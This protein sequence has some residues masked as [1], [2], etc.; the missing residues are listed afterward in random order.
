MR[1]ATREWFSDT[2]GERPPQGKRPKISAIWNG[3]TIAESDATVVV[4]G[5]H[6][7]SSGAVRG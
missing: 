1:S 7:F 6:Y 3:V 2:E 5:H 4:E